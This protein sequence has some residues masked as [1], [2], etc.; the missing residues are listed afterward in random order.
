MLR[1]P[2]GPLTLY[3]FLTALKMA[4]DQEKS[5]NPQVAFSKTG[6]KQDYSPGVELKEKNYIS[7]CLRMC[8]NTVIS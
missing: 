8:L 3:K 4:C 2:T 5:K 6:F 1:K 7:N